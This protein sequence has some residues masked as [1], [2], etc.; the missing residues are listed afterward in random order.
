MRFPKKYRPPALVSLADKTQ[1][2][3]GASCGNGTSPDGGS[4]SCE[5]GTSATGCIGSGSGDTAGCPS[6]F[7]PS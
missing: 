4:S 2:V 1:A 3:W 5:W 6:G 7:I